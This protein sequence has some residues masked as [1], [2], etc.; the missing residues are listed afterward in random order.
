MA[1]LAHIAAEG[2][3]EAVNQMTSQG[4]TS[5]LKFKF[6]VPGCRGKSSKFKFVLTLRSSRAK[7]KLYH[8]ISSSSFEMDLEYTWG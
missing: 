4:Q 1:L 2:A 3:A 8:L 7:Y 5:S 6:Y